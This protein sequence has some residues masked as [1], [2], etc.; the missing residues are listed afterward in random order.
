M[1]Y[2][3]D[4][5]DEFALRMMMKY[6]DKEFKNISSDDLGLETE[7]EKKSAEKTGARK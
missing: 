4:N 7:E 5:V 2:L 3:T 6:A 1:L